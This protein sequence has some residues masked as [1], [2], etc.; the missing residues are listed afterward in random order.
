MNLREESRILRDYV[1]YNLPFPVSAGLS[2]DRTAE[3]LMTGKRHGPKLLLLKVIIIA[4]C[5]NNS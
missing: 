2:V 3:H 5:K 1:N 4:G